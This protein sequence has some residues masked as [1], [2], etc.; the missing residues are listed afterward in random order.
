M[1]RVTFLSI[2]CV[3]GASIA[4]PS[5]TQVAWAGRAGAII[6]WNMATFARHQG[7]SRSNWAAGS[8]PAVF[9]VGLDGTV[10][11]DSWGDAMQAANLTYA[12][13][14]AKHN[15]GF[16]TWPTNVSLPS[17]SPY[18]YSIQYSSCPSCNAVSEK[19][20]AHIQS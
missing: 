18:N 1:R 2:Y 9:G 19:E 15:C 13:Y 20:E 6:H 5:T 8:D 11:T 7:C 12:V 16:T 3:L 14:V 4:V 10:D 17:G